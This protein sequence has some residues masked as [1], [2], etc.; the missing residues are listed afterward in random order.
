MCQICVGRP[1]VMRL[2]VGRPQPMGNN[3]SKDL[4]SQTA[5]STQGPVTVPRF[6][7]TE[8]EEPLTEN[9]SPT[10]PGPASSE[11]FGGLQ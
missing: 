2:I 4:A 1:F 7:A 5:G 3:T 10:D 6:H 8:A 9:T 11:P